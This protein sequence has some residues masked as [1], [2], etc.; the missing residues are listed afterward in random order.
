MVN[1]SHSPIYA[2]LESREPD[3]VAPWA[4]PQTVFRSPARGQRGLMACQVN[5]ADRTTVIP[6][7]GM[8]HEGDLV[9]LG[10]EANVGDPAAA[11]VNNL[12]N[13]ILQAVPP[14]GI[15]HHCQLAV[16]IRSGPANILQNLTGSATS[17]SEER[18]VG[19]ECRSRWSPYH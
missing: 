19:K 7:R 17:R 3:L 6:S 8:V 15:V 18:R 14:I 1:S 16:G 2:T 5:D 9:S 4:P 10:R 11:F 13:G 12:A